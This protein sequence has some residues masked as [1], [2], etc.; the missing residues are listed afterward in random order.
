M[1]KSRMYTQYFFLKSSDIEIISRGMQEAV[2][3]T[4]FGGAS[5][6]LLARPKS[7]INGGHQ[8]SDKYILTRHSQVRIPVGPH[9]PRHRTL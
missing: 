7:H 6:M 1:S 5:T 8:R 9:S 2:E 4:V 3:H